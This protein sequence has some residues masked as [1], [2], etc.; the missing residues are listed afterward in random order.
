MH[1]RLAIALPAVLLLALGCKHAQQPP[2]H[3][4]VA[5]PPTQAEPAKAVPLPQPPTATTATPP[6]RKPMLSVAMYISSGAKAGF[7]MPIAGQQASIRVTPINEKGQPVR[8]VQPVLGAQIVLVAMRADMTWMTLQRA[9][10]WSDPAHFSHEFKVTF[11]AGGSHVLYFLFR[12]KDSPVAAV[13]VFI[14]VDGKA[15]ALT[16]PPELTLRYAGKDGLQATLETPEEPFTVCKTSAISSTWTRKGKA[17]ALVADGPSVHYVAIDAGLGGVSVARSTGPDAH[18][19]L[20]FEKPGRYRVLAL[21]EVAGKKSEALLAQFAL[22]VTGEA[23]AGGCP[24]EAE[25]GSDSG[26][27]AGS[28]AKHK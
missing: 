25:T 16:P 5:L 10:Q 3:K 27:A 14:Q 22:A 15:P 24:A 28:E 6:V 12:Q 7:G 26:S 23:P 18:A 2:A 9:P 21:A 13:P 8:E 17:L 1:A 19:T 11:P 20:T 4:T